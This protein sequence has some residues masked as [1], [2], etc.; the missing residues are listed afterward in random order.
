MQSA[1]KFPDRVQHNYYTCT[2]LLVVSVSGSG[3]IYHCNNCVVQYGPN[4]LQL[5]TQRCSMTTYLSPHASTVAVNTK[6][7]RSIFVVQSYY[8]SNFTV[9]DVLFYSMV[10]IVVRSVLCCQR[11]LAVKSKRLLR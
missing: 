8:G 5:S 6:F 3:K 10:L 1:C 9:L 7:I 2:F 4:V 11:R